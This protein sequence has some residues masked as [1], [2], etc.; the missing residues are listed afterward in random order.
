MAYVV[1]SHKQQKIAAEG[2]GLIVTFNYQENKKALLPPEI[3][4]R[5]ETLE[6][7]IA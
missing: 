7:S 5:I 6:A 4:Q 1:V 3:R 2:T